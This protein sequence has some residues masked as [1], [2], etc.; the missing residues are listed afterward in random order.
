MEIHLN[1]LRSV[2][3]INAGNYV[4]KTEI[5]INRKIM[6]TY[7]PRPGFDHNYL[8]FLFSFFECPPIKDKK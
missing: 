5:E 8:T 2:D 7:T 1:I 6:N 3:C 4:L